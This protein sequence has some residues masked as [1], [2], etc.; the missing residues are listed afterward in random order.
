MRFGRRAKRWEI[1]G[2]IIDHHKRLM[3]RT[4]A[5][6]KAEA[7]ANKREK[8]AY[9]M[10]KLL[11]NTDGNTEGSSCV[12]HKGAT[13]ESLSTQ[14]LLWIARYQRFNQRPQ[15]S[16]ESWFIDSRVNNHT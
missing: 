11:E 13:L 5:G 1:S 9:F 12:L 14:L 10:V 4:E 2:R 15:T 6:A 16:L 8:T 7:E 3:P